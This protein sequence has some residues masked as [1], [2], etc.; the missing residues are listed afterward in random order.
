MTALPNPPLSSSEP[1]P[2]LLATLGRIHFALL[3]V[4]A[5][6]AGSVLAGWLVPP[7]GRLLPVGWD[8]MKANTAVLTLAT[9]LSITL[10]QP[11]RSPH[12]LRAASIFAVL[13]T[14]VAAATLVEYLGH[15]SLPIDTVLAGDASSPLPGR[16]SFQTAW[17]FL[18]IGIILINLRARKRTF[19]NLIDL[20]TLALTLIVLVFI[21]GYLFGAF[22]LYGT[23]I[24]TRLA[25]QTLFCISLL[26]FV[27]VTRRSE[28]G[29]LSI[30]LGSGIGGKTARV[31]APWA[32]CLPF[33]LSIVRGL[34]VRF[35][36]IPPAYTIALTA[37]IMAVFGFCLVLALSRRTDHLENAIRD[38][39]LRDELTK[40]Y[41]RRGFYFLAEQ[42]LRH[43]RRA[44]EPFFVLFV[45]MDNLKLINDAHGHD[46]GSEH[47]RRLAELLSRNFRETDVVARLGGDEFVVAG[48]ADEPALSIALSRF[49]RSAAELAADRSTPH[50]LDFSLGYVI[51][52]SHGNSSLDQLVERADAVMYDAKR[53]KKGAQA[54]G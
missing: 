15:I 50:P 33:V 51:S 8:L 43:A 32:L 16:L 27:I 10:W 54:G 13:V 34:V 44:K 14:L 46:I 47:L 45:D 25:P 21:S 26:T 24:A 38:L 37:S 48:R 20:L 31:A 18:L 1:D 35:T 9:T 17:S 49:R 6:T 22:H 19:A 12:A 2:R 29:I 4:V 41:N 3:I 23:S 5:A 40:L 42:A 28:Y 7:I 30:L 36:A 39:S 53:K 52:E 11:R